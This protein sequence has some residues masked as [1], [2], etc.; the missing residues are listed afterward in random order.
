MPSYSSDAGQR[1]VDRLPVLLTVGAL[2]MLLLCA[3]PLRAEEQTQPVAAGETQPSAR[4][5]MEAEPETVTPGESVTV[6][7]HLSP[8]ES[9]AGFQVVITWD[10]TGLELADPEAVRLG[11]A[12]PDDAPG[13]VVN[14]ENGGRLV[15]LVVTPEAQFDSRESEILRFDLTA[16]ED[17]QSGKAA[18]EWGAAPHEVLLCDANARLI[19]PRP[20]KIDGSVTIRG[21]SE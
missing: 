18:L 11:A 21:N 13:P 1:C 12:I 17:A 6:Q 5:W 3:F 8:T 7:V 4:L 9:L 2:A 19:E 15:V 20:E 16:R 14:A 10:P